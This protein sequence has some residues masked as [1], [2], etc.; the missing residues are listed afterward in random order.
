MGLANEVI[1]RHKYLEYESSKSWNSRNKIIF[2]LKPW[3]TTMLHTYHSKGLD[4]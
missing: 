2:Q 4:Y 3:D 1:H